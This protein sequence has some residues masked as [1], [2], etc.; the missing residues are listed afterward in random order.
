MIINLKTMVTDDGGVFTMFACFL[1]LMSCISP[2]S[3]LCCFP[4]IL[5]MIG[6]P[7]GFVLDICFCPAEV[8]ICGFMGAFDI[9]VHGILPNTTLNGIVPRILQEMKALML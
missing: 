9:I 8:L 1:A 3:W 5:S 4:C 7:E 6:V 2:P